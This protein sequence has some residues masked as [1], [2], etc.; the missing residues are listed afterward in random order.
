MMMIL[1]VVA[2]KISKLKSRF[3][4]MTEEALTVKRYGIKPCKS[5]TY[6]NCNDIKLQLIFLTNLG[7]FC[8][9][10]EK[11]LKIRSGNYSIF[12]EEETK[13]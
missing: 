11:L 9:S 13:I 12:T 4:D 8:L 3:A 6:N 1:N 7:Y 2:D 10:D 5:Y